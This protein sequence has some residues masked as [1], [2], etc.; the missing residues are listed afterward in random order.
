DVFV[1]S[2]VLQYAWQILRDSDAL[3]DD[4][5]LHWI[6]LGG[7]WGILTMVALSLWL[8]VL[9][10]RSLPF[11]WA[12]WI[13]LGQASGAYVGPKTWAVLLIAAAASVLAAR[14]SPQRDEFAIGPRLDPL[15]ARVLW[16]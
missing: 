2:P 15:H 13:I 7:I 5:W 14:R 10:P 6:Y 11:C 3:T 8:R 16:C 1:N 9:G 12:G 4:F